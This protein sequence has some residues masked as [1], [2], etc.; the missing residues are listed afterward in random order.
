MGLYLILLAVWGEGLSNPDWPENNVHYWR[1]FFKGQYA[2][3]YSTANDKIQAR[4]DR[5]QELWD[6]IKFWD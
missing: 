4:Y 6:K 1:C 5:R 2:S 3:C